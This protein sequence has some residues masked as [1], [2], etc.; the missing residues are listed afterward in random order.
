MFCFAN[1]VDFAKNPSSDLEIFGVRTEMDHIFINHVRFQND[2]LSCK[3]LYI[4]GDLSVEVCFNSL[5]LNAAKNFC[6]RKLESPD[7]LREL[8]QK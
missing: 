4:R 3:I 8:V 6:T 7:E 2:H 5:M 1:C